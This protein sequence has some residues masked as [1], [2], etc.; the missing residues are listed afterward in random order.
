VKAQAI[1]FDL[2]NTLVDDSFH[3]PLSKSDISER[4][5]VPYSD[6]LN[7]YEV[8]YSKRML[9]KITFYE[10]LREISV[11]YRGTYEENVLRQ[12]SDKHIEHKQFLYKFVDKE[13]IDVLSRLVGCG[14]RLGLV[15]NIGIDELDG[16]EGSDLCSMFLASC[17]S[18]REGLV[19]PD[20]RIYQLACQ[21]LRVLPSEAIF[22]GDGSRGELRGAH[23]CGL[24]VFW[25]TWYTG[26]GMGKVNDRDCYHKLEALADVLKVVSC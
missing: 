11:R 1:I 19:K 7:G 9:G 4:L 12:I 6:F 14:I 26:D 3:K 10:M 22:I 20:V 21:K 18:C 23:E 16:W 25:A 15:S 5:G 24:N 17:F 8:L 2:I 13:V